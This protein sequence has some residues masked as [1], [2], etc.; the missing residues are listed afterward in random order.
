MALTLADGTNITDANSYVTLAL[1]RDYNNAR[2]V[3]LPTDDAEAT[4]LVVKAFDFIE[5]LEGQFKGEKT[6]AGQI[7][8]WPRTGVYPDNGDYMLAADMI[9]LQIKMAQCYLAGVAMTVDLYAVKDTRAVIEEAIG[10][11]IT[12]YSATQGATG[13]PIMPNLDGILRPLLRQL[14]GSLTTVRV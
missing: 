1:A 13:A 10:P 2:G 6:Y 8:A 3:S 11:I 9:P 12:K 5:A 4:A 7:T 14:R